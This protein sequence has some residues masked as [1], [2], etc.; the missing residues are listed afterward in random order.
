MSWPRS[1]PTPCSATSACRATS[2]P[3]WPT[4]RRRSPTPSP[5]STRRSRKPAATRAWPAPATPARWSRR[6]IGCATI[7]S[8][9]ATIIPSWR[10]A[11]ETLGGALSD[12]LSMSE[13][14]RRRLKEAWGIGARV[15]PQAEL[16]NV[17]QLYD[18]DRRLFLLSSQLRPENRTFALAYQLALVEFAAVLDRMV[19]EAAPPDEGVAPAAPH[20]PRQ[21]CGR[22]DHDALWPLPHKRRGVCATRSTG[23]AANMAPMSSRSRTGCTTLE[24]ARARAACPSSCCGSIRPET[25]RKRYAGD[26]FPLLALR[27]HLPALEPARRLPGRRAG[28]HP[29]D[30]NA[31]RPSLFHRRPDDRAADQD[32]TC[33]AGCWRSAWAATSAMRTNCPAPRAMTWPMRRSPRSARPAPSARGS[34][35]A[36][37]RPR[38]PGGCWRSTGRKK[39]I[40][41]LP[42]RRRLRARPARVRARRGPSGRGWR[43]RRRSTGGSSSACRSGIGGA[44][45]VR[46]RAGRI[47]RAS[48]SKRAAAG[49]T[50]AIAEAGRLRI[51]IAVEDRLGRGDAARPEARARHFMAIGFAGD[52]VGQAGNSA[53]MRRRRAARKAG[54]REVE[55][56]P[57]EMDRAGLAAG[58]RRG[59]ARR[60]ARSAPARRAV[61]RPNRD[62]RCAARRRRRTARA[63]AISLG[64]PLKF[65]GRPCAVEHRRPGR[66]EARRCCPASQRHR[67]ALAV[68]DAKHDGVAAQVEGQFE[69]A[70]AGRDRRRSPGPR[71][72]GGASTCQP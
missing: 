38:P 13:P 55:A 1:S 6:K 56:A 32:R 8:S 35:A 20:E 24:P 40:S 3:S 39:T 42:V 18:A 71:R 22:G 25:S 57:E 62:R 34:T 11:A 45:H 9:T 26:Q 41:P 47:R 54:H 2:W 66:D 65:D 59:S 28:R 49:S 29:A 16:G 36:I 30:R 53:G 17:S 7:S 69:A 70:V 33:R 15:V 12:P 43:R 44:P 58:S 51:G 23:C 48:A 5:G 68:A 60:S 61:A 64:V 46:H 72:P 19:A 31:R 14:M 21:L 67:I 27:R 37:A 4:M 10:N 50:R 63:S 52:A